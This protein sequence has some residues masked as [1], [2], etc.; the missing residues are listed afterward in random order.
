MRFIHYIILSLFIL[1]KVSFTFAQENDSL[2]VINSKYDSILSSDSYFLDVLFY[3]QKNDV[4][5][6][7]LGPFG[8]PSYSPT[9]F[10]LFL[11]NRFYLNNHSSSSI[12]TLKGVK[13]FTNISYINAS[14]KEQ[15]LSL[16]HFQ[17]MGKSFNVSFNYTRLT[18]PG[19]YIN[20][21]SN[22][23]FFDFILD[24]KSKEHIYA[25][26]FSAFVKRVFLNENG[27]LLNP[28]DFENNLYSNRR[29]YNV[30]LETSSSSNKKYNYQLKQQLKLLR[31]NN[32]SII[33]NGIF[34]KLKSNFSSNTYVFNDND[35]L[36]LIYNDV[37]IDTTSM[38]DSIFSASFANEIAFGVTKNNFDFDIFTKLDF[39]Y[40]TQSFG[41]DT[42]YFNSYVGFKIKNR[43]DNFT[44]NIIS[45]YG[46]SG[47]RSGDFDADFSCLFILNKNIEL[48]LNSSYHLNEP[49]LNFVNYVSNHFEWNNNFKKQSVFSNYLNFHFKPLNANFSIENKFINDFIFLD[50]NS[51]ASQSNTSNVISSIKL[52]KDYQLLNLHFRSA[53]IYQLT[54]DNILFPLPDFIGRQL[55]YYENFLFKKA[56]KFQIGAN[57]SFTT[58]YYAYGYMPA[59][60]KFHVQS[61]SKIGNYP[62]FDLFINTKLKRAQIFFKY[63]HFTSGM[64]GYSYYSSPTYPRLDKLFKFG[65]SW[66]M[67]D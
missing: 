59:L 5:I 28:L 37:F 15:L 50:S 4:L 8:S 21:E 46:V 65:V 7:N 67:F 57:L 63:E 45:K 41:L 48:N 36:S 20:Q 9:S 60:N 43:H 33:S 32:D 52:S 54:S 34:I 1:I 30:N 3:K 38:V 47:Y 51:L 39:N 26:Q 16:T 19:S 42:T 35:P 44:Y 22:N 29:N 12:S 6:N 49:N 64:F 40:Y 55:I 61:S 13:P 58:D 11:D 18:S 24:F 56:L 23:T 25:I 17:N 10:G 27:G 53:I 31:F 66:N 14:R 62:Y 2:Y